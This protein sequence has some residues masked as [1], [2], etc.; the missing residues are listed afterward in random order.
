M[1]LIKEKLSSRNSASSKAESVGSYE[2]LFRIL[3]NFCELQFILNFSCSQIFHL[4]SSF[5][6][7][8]VFLAKQVYRENLKLWIFLK[9]LFKYKLLSVLSSYF[10]PSEYMW[11]PIHIFHFERKSSR[12]QNYKSKIISSKLH[13][14]QS[15]WNQ[16]RK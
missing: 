6:K 5:N 1:R 8:I 15:V 2:K 16:Q 12:F 11:L 4:N 14:F 9:L 3:L 7:Q 13:T 10:I